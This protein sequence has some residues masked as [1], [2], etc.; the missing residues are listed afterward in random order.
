MSIFYQL[1]YVLK[2]AAVSLV[3]R[4]KSKKKYGRYFRSHFDFLMSNDVAKQTEQGLEDLNNFLSHVRNSSRFYQDLPSDNDIAQ[5]PI[6]QKEQVI[7]HYSA[8]VLGK[9]D[10]EVKSSG[11]S[12][13]PLSVPYTLS[14]YQRE[15]AFWWYHRSFGGVARGD[16]VATFAGHK[17]TNP[18]RNHPPF[19]VHNRVEN[20]VIF[21]S[22]HLSAHNIKDY[23]RELNSFC[24]DFIH[25]YP[26]SIF[27][28][29]RYL[30]DNGIK[31]NF[32]PKMIATASET[33]LDF[34]RKAI[35]SAFNTKLFI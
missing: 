33:T 28:I 15:Y 20:Q 9:P 24:P 1:P 4:T 17:V 32:R 21:S 8:F 11:T 29:A 12:G 25:G 23:I 18:N 14:S 26:S 30:L 27:L 13:T 34:Q 35:E 5:M 22:Y 2:N 19:W 10:M 7:D 6:L 3:A 16:R 31:L